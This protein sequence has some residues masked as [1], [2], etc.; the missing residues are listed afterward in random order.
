MSSTLRAVTLVFAFGMPVASALAQSGVSI[1]DVRQVGDRNIVAVAAP[2]PD[3]AVT[4]VQRGD[5]NR[6]DLSASQ[7]LGNV[8][9]G[10]GQLGEGN[11]ANFLLAGQPATFAGVTARQ[12]GARN[13]FEL[14]QTI[15]GVVDAQLRQHGEGNAASLKQEGADLSADLTQIGDFNSLE[16]V[17]IG[18]NLGLQATQVGS[19]LPITIQQFGHGTPGMGPIVVTQTR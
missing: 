3:Q 8:R 10:L 15:S 4:V 5:T 14:T 6:A 1:V 17:Q 9:V 16:A 18:S 12:V 19:H 11:E 13:R 2:N 7:A